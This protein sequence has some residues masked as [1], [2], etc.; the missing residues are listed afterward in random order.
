MEILRGRRCWTL[1]LTGP[2]V[3]P[4]GFLV[5][6]NGS[7]KRLRQNKYFFTYWHHMPDSGAVRTRKL[8]KGALVNLARGTGATP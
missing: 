4:F 3:R 2:Y 5:R 1:L 8:R 7:T 6:H